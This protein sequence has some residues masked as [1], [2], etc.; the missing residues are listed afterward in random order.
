MDA[1]LIGPLD[2][3]TLAPARAL[4]LAKLAACASVALL[5]VVVAVVQAPRVLAGVGALSP[6]SAT[7]T[8]ISAVPVSG[9]SDPS[10]AP[11]GRGCLASDVTVA[12]GGGTTGTARWCTPHGAGA[13]EVGDTAAIWVLPGWDPV[14]ATGVA[15][16]LGFDIAALAVFL[17]G[18]LGTAWYG[19]DLASLVALRT[20]PVRTAA[21]AGRIDRIAVGRGVLGKEGRVTIGVAIDRPADGDAYR[22]L[23]LALPGPL[24]RSLLGARVTVHAVR[25]G[26]RRGPGG[27]FVLV[28]GADP[29]RGVAGVAGAGVTGNRAP[30]TGT[31]VAL[32]RRLHRIASRP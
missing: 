4:L 7:V 18:A 12:W 32:G 16:W 11:A 9:T 10:G 6:V 13:P 1:A 24:D 27:P 30:V 17:A 15:S 19:R 23:R 26:E 25:P 21:V 29:D 14:Q 8:A 3:G 28:R 20:R 2:R 22:P 31:R 5:A